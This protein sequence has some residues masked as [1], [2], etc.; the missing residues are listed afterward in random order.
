MSN[1][2]DKKRKVYMEIYVGNPDRRRKLPSPD[3]KTHFVESTRYYDLY[4][5]IDK[6]SRNITGYVTNGR[7]HATKTSLNRLRKSKQSWEK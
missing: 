2:D 1:S 3:S 5:I 7:V 6:K 4:K